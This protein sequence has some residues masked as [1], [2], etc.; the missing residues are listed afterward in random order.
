M[1]R[2]MVGIRSSNRAMDLPRRVTVEGTPRAHRYAV[3]VSLLFLEGVMV[4][5]EVALDR[6]GGGQAEERKMEI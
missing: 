3:F 6:W 1:A 2:G 4:E 5:V